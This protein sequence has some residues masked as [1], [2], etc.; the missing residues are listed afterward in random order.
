MPQDS[1][2]S[3]FMDTADERA[4]VSGLIAQMRSGACA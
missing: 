2:L 1:T 3:E 4:L